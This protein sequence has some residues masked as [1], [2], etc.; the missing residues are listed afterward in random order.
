[1]LST[2]AIP[3]IKMKE[4]VIT[5]R[6]TRITI[7]KGMIV[8]DTITRM[9]TTIDNGDFKGKDDISKIERID[10]VDPFGVIHF[11]TKSIEM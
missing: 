3:L 10:R 6:T 11:L 5:T 4:M 2:K 9:I 7:I 1:M 8:E